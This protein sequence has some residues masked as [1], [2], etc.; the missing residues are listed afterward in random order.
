MD[1]NRH[2]NDAVESNSDKRPMENTA[3]RD[4]EL[5]HKILQQSYDEFVAGSK[6]LEEELEQEL[7][8]AGKPHKSINFTTLI[9]EQILT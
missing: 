3:V 8:E 5:E 6:L 9:H 2:D 4:L 1:E 7:C